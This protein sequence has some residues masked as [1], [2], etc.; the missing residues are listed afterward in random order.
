MIIHLQILSTSF[1]FTFILWNKAILNLY[2][3]W[4]AIFNIVSMTHN[5][6]FRFWF[7]NYRSWNSN[8]D[9]WWRIMPSIVCYSIYRGDMYLSW[10][11]YNCWIL[12]R[13]ADLDVAV[14]SVDNDKTTNIYMAIA[15]T[16]INHNITVWLRLNNNI[17]HNYRRIIHT[18]P[19]PS[20]SSSNPLQELQH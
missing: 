5:I 13:S 1:P 6:I 4:S 15:T 10:I 3:I 11:W 8:H 2:Q 14:T 7:R 17:N 9:G 16:T 18:T 19:Y 20:Y 12:G